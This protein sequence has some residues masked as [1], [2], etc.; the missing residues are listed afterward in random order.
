[1][2][3]PKAR[4]ALLACLAILA[5]LVT[6]FGYC[7]GRM[8]PL[9]FPGEVRSGH[10][11]ALVEYLGPPSEDSTLSVERVVEHGV[12]G[13]PVRRE[14]LTRARSSQVRVLVWR[15]GG[16]VC[17]RQVFFALTDPNTSLILFTDGELARW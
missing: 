12:E 17:S 10:V 14:R 15:R 2:R 13:I 16:I 9:G 3:R 1:M 6:V 11:E 5:V 8:L 4:S 7:W